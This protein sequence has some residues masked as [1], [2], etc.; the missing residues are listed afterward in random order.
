[1]TTTVVIF[2][3]CS[4]TAGLLLRK[5]LK[6]RKIEKEQ[7]TPIYEEIFEKEPSLEMHKNDAYDQV[8][9]QKK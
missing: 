9:H 2:I 4:F 7:D 8:V 5:M 3:T 1:M 6:R